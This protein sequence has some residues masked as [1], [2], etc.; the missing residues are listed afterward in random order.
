M[1][2]TYIYIYIYIIQIKELL[3]V[4]CFT[5]TIN[6]PENISYSQLLQRIYNATCRSSASCNRQL[7]QTAQD[8][9]RNPD[10][11]ISDWWMSATCRLHI[12][13]LRIARSH[14]TDERFGSWW[15]ASVP[16]MLGF[17]TRT[18]GS[19]PLYKSI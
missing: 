7:W 10:Q 14:S 8:K 13:P 3:R 16:R 11:T 17:G 2:C 19:V 15:K 9:K 6:L 5:G 12:F 1:Y 4:I 18:R